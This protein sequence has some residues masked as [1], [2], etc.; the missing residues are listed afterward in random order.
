MP[1]R[2]VPPFLRGFLGHVGHLLR[3]PVKTVRT[4]GLPGNP[5][6]QRKRYTT[7]SA[8]KVHG[9][10]VPLRMTRGEKPA[11]LGLNRRQGGPTMRELPKKVVKK[12]GTPPRG[13][14]VAP[15]PH[16]VPLFFFGEPVHA[17]KWYFFNPVPILGL[18]KHH[19][20]AQA[21]ARKK[22]YRGTR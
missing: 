16:L 10:G 11:L 20:G 17:P 19:V 3:F 9:G 12:G 21:G 5:S 6:Q 1:K 2:G 4:P 7:H 14:Y 18:K 22:I 8:P 13:V 15:S